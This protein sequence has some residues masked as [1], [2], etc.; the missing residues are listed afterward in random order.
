MNSPETGQ[1]ILP[2]TGDLETVPLDEYRSGHCAKVAE[3]LAD[4]REAGQLM[5]MGVCV[6]R[7]VMVLR[8]GDPLILKVLGSR[9]GVSSR[10]ANRVRVAACPGDGCDCDDCQE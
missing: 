10:L 5:A 2:I 6:G 7:T 9:I 1:P 3:V 4:D 8:H